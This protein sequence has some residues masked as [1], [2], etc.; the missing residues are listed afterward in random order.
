MNI[1]ITILFALIGSFFGIRV[2]FW[3]WG[4]TPSGKA[5]KKYIEELKEMNEELRN[6]L[7]NPYIW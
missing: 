1:M 2:A 5:H 7:K 6:K 4:L 3:L